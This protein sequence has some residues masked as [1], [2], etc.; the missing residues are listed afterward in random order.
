M[1]ACDFLGHN[2]FYFQREISTSKQNPMQGIHIIAKL[3]ITY[4]C[5]PDLTIW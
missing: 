5:D 3:D 1:P 2:I 4:S